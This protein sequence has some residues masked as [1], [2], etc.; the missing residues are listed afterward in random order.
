MIRF[1]L[2]MVILKIPG[3][4]PNSGAQVMCVKQT[5]SSDFQRSLQPFWCVYV[6]VLLKLSSGA[7]LPGD[8]TVQ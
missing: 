1:V 8:A 3:Q 6:C 2:E 4:D 7:L 5:D